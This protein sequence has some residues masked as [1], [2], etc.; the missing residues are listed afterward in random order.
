MKLNSIIVAE[1]SCLN[2]G[3][4][5]HLRYFRISKTSA[6]HWQIGHR[7]DGNQKPSGVTAGGQGENLW[8]LRWH[9]RP[10]WL[11]RSIIV[12]IGTSLLQFSLWR[13]T[14][15]ST[16]FT[17][18]KSSVPLEIPQ[19]FHLASSSHT[20]WAFFSYRSW[21]TCASPVWPSWVPWDISDS[22]RCLQVLYPGTFKASY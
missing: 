2:I 1:F 16:Y 12:Y 18:L 11:N 14:G 4:S 20:G 7:T 6:Q 10:T 9:K 15:S 5:C 22:T 13:E 3:F 21:D 8:C 19:V 17:K